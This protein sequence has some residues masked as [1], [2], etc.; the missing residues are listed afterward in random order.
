MYTQFYAFKEKPFKLVPD[1]HFLYMS[2]VHQSAIAHLQYGLE[3]RNGFIVITGEVGSGKTL[4]LRVLLQDLPRTTQVAR[5]INTNFNAKELLEHILNEF[6]IETHDETKPKMLSLLSQLLLKSYAERKEVLLVID[7][8]QNLSIDALEEL[9]MVSNL[10]TS[11]DKLIQIVMV[12]QPQLRYKLNLPDLEQLKQRVTVQYHLPALSADDSIGY[13]NHRLAVARGEPVEMFTPGAL[14]RAYE[15]SGGVPR[16]INVV[17]DAGLRLGYVEERKTIDEEIMNEVIEELKETEKSSEVKEPPGEEAPAPLDRGIV[18]LNKKFQTLYDQMQ[19]VYVR[20][21]EESRLVYERLLNVEKEMVAKESLFNLQERE[22]MIFDKER[23]IHQKLFEVSKRLDEINAMKES[24]EE[25]KIQVQ[26]KIQEVDLHLSTLQ[27]KERLAEKNLT[28]GAGERTTEDAFKNK[29]VQLEGIQERLQTREE[30][31]NEKMDSLKKIIYELEDKKVLLDQLGPQKTVEDRLRELESQQE[32]VRRQEEELVAKM[33]LLEKEIRSGRLLPQGSTSVPSTSSQANQA[34]Q[35]E[36][37]QDMISHVDSLKSE[38]DSLEAHK[39]LLDSLENG[40]KVSPLQSQQVHK[41]DSSLKKK[42][43][44][45]LKKIERVKKSLTHTEPKVGPEDPRNDAF[46]KKERLLGKKFDELKKLIVKIERKRPAV[47]RALGK[48]DP[49]K[50]RRLD[51]AAEPSLE[52]E[53][54]GKR[55]N[56]LVR[57]ILEES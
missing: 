12:G 41:N 49:L 47:S 31:L 36:L 2:D 38:M 28:G 5:V 54:P 33:S 35:T 53:V 24:L 13:I 8:A 27:E 26:D 44:E 32:S 6:G 11:T 39:Q 21:G 56:R 18:D 15:Y 7:E 25:K 51:G 3:D 22:R 4:L 9:R 46:K 14:E 19:K 30:E 50:T 29:L 42:E 23:E 37:L 34:G 57:K 20:K 43:S 17:C 52:K 40:E 16:L 55:F 48:G 45:L 1:P 10:E